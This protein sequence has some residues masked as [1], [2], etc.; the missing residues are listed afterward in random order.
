VTVSSTSIPALF[1]EKPVY[2]SDW[3]F[4]AWRH[5]RPLRLLCHLIG[6]ALLVLPVPLAVVTRDPW[7]LAPIALSIPIGSAG[8]RNFGRLNTLFF[9][10]LVLRKICLGEYGKDLEYIRMK[11]IHRAD[12][13]L[14]GE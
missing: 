13:A 5:K 9:L 11:I 7:W 8:N 12:D 10:A 6:W 2:L 4:F 3:E 14:L 1:V